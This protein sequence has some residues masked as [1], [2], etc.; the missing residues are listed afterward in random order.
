MCLL[1]VSRSRNHCGRRK[2][3]MSFG[4]KVRH[5]FALLATI[6]TL[7]L[8]SVPAQQTP[9]TSSETTVPPITVRASAT[10]QTPDGQFVNSFIAT[11]VR[12]TGAKFFSCISTA[13]K[14][15]PELAAKLVVCALNIARLNTQSVTGQL[16]AG[17]IDQIVKAAVSSAPAFAVDIVKAAIES[18]PYAKSS[19]V[20]AAVAAAPDQEAEIV[21]NSTG[22][23]SIFASA[24]VTTVSPLNDVAIRPVSPEQ[25][26][27][28]P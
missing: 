19:I 6:A 23:M 15:R 3:P 8:R 25:A 18:E 22:S 26:P 9:S 24:G 17:V 28:I 16:P 20:A 10:A 14:A 2:P 11:A 21:A 4:F 12:L 5:R 13:A 27:I 7:S 1:G